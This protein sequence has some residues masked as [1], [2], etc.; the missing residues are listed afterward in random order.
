MTNAHGFGPLGPRAATERPPARA[1]GYAKQTWF[2]DASAPGAKDGTPVDASWLNHILAN[3]LHAAIQGGV[4]ISNEA[5]DH[6]L[7]DTIVKVA[8]RFIATAAKEGYTIVKG[9]GD[10]WRAVPHAVASLSDVNVNEVSD[11]D[12]LAYFDKKWQAT[13]LAP[14]RRI[15]AINPPS[16]T[17]DQ[18]R[19]YDVGSTWMTASTL[20]FCL[21]ASVGAAVW[22]PLIKWSELG[23]LAK[24]HTVPMSLVADSDG[25]VRMTDSERIALAALSAVGVPHVAAVDPDVD[26]DD[27]FAV[28]SRWINSSTHEMFVCIDTTA[29]AA[30]WVKSSLTLDE[31]GPFA[32]MPIAT[33][34]EALAGASAAV[35]MTPQRTREAIDAI[36]AARHVASVA[37]L[38]TIDP[39]RH[40]LAYVIGPLRWGFFR[41]VDYATVSDLVTADTQNILTK[42]ST[43]DAN[44]V[45]LRDG[46]DASC[47][48]LYVDWARN[49]ADAGVAAAFARCV[50]LGTAMNRCG[51]LARPGMRLFWP[52]GE[53]VWESTLS[54]LVSNLHNIAHPEGGTYVKAAAT[55]NVAPMLRRLGDSAQVGVYVNENIG[56]EGIVFDAT[57]RPFAKYL[58][59]PSDGSPI[60]DPEADWVVGSGALGL[61]VTG[62]NLSP[63]MVAVAGGNEVGSVT[64]VAGGSGFKGHST[65]P[66]LPNTVPLWFSGGGTI[67]RH[68]SGYATISGGAIV[69][70]TIT[71][72][73]LYSGTPTVSVAGGYAD[74]RLLL[75]INRRNGAAYDQVNDKFAQ[76]V[77]TR[78]VTIRR[79]KFIGHKWTLD[80]LGCCESIVEDN[81]FEDCGTTEAIA[82]IIYN[83]DYFVGATTITIADRNVIRNNRSR[84]RN[85]LHPGIFCYNSATGSTLIEGNQHEASA[86]VQL[87]KTPK[88]GYVCIIRNNVVRNLVFTAYSSHFGEAIG[89]SN[90]II[91]G[92][93][94]DG[95][96]G[97]G[98]GGLYGLK[99]ARFMD[100]T[101]R[102]VW[103]TAGGIRNSFLPQCERTKEGVG[104]MPYV[105]QIGDGS[106]GATRYAN[107]LASGNDT[108]QTDCS[109]INET[110]IDD[111]PAA[112]QPPCFLMMSRF[113]AGSLNA[114]KNVRIE[115]VRRLKTDGTPNPDIPLL[116]NASVA[117][118]VL[119]AAY[120]LRMV[121]NPDHASEAPVIVSQTFAAGSNV[122]YTIAAGFPPKKVSVEAYDP[123]DPSRM[124]R[125]EW[126]WRGAE[127]NGWKVARARWTTLGSPGV[128]GV[129]TDKALQLRNAAGAVVFE[130]TFTRWRVDGFTVTVTTSTAGCQAE[131]ICEP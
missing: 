117:D 51:A 131:F 16:P 22:M 30:V 127:A 25:Y 115:G 92:N 122:A 120:S 87:G 88:N 42:R 74:P 6:Y 85:K 123:A 36:S 39:A 11:G 21:S 102:N 41:K 14:K 52:A 48:F 49:S 18:R 12:V 64:V 112:Q 118:D 99:N 47:S 55:L 79:C 110:I 76:I 40:A 38:A 89:G 10:D 26:D 103:Q 82:P 35:G 101:Q 28:G 32:T 66:Y 84:V 98:F 34:E 37:D 105:F 78:G 4:P 13:K 58:T 46:A 9:K 107:L 80:L 86:F 81:L 129:V 56:I 44:V 61:G 29:G 116:Y 71:D 33:N 8:R 50:T 62:L 2:R 27:G 70:T 72:K 97:P 5:A 90:V 43:V 75:E 3:L 17:D 94:I 68:A 63:V 119:E 31:L 125:A 1:D 19:G 114:M 53:C 45:W 24:L 93:L 121:G 77:Q 111:R 57:L 108:P 124:F 83:S 126:V 7:F 59:N 106:T 104:L 95:S 96:Q 69:S 128:S 65:W 91:D 15:G 113:G 73:G 130:A 109:F 23:N 60:T 67:H 20:Y 54:L 100:N